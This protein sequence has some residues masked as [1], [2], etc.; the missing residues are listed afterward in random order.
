MSNVCICLRSLDTLLTGGGLL[1]GSLVELCGPTAGGKTL[2][3]DS[4]AL[5]F[6][7]THR[8]PV[9]YVSTKNACSALR[10]FRL[11][12]A[13][14]GAAA[15]Q[16]PHRH[17]HETVLKTG[18][19]QQHQ[20]SG[21]IAAAMSLLRCETVHSLHELQLL[22]RGLLD[23]TSDHSDYQLLIV[24]SL[25]AL[26][27]TFQGSMHKAGLSQMTETLG[28]LRRLADQQQKCVLV[29]TLVLSDPA[30][31][32][33]RRQHVSTISRV[34][35]AFASI[36]LFVIRHRTLPTTT[37]GKADG[38]RTQAYEIVLLKSI[39]HCSGPN[40]SCVI[41]LGVPI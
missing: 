24:D 21:D 28:L 3:A 4:I 22:L 17:D 18:R 26:L 7:R 14:V 11:L 37:P 1:T 38:V 36:R 39:Y 5:H 12:K 27:L 15:E 32:D 30:V 31:A 20:R 16:Q 2:L 34:W 8:V 40:V 19:H 10:W 9:Y 41:E 13:G 23:H 6:V 25:S 35:P 33:A 29:E